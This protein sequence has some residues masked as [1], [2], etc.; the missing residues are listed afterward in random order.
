MNQ[1]DYKITISNKDLR[2]KD[3][4]SEQDLIDNIDNLFPSI[5]LKT[6]KKLSDSFIIKYILS[7]N[8]AKIREDYDITINDLC[9]YYPNFGK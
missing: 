1:L 3:N 8:Y 9:N 7:D 6:Q 4:Y 2:E 5:I